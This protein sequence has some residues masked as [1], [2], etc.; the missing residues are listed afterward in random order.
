MTDREEQGFPYFFG[1]F[2]RLF[3]LEILHLD[4][5]CRCGVIRSALQ[6]EQEE[7][8]RGSVEGSRTEDP[9]VNRRWVLDSICPPGRSSLPSLSEAKDLLP[10][11]RGRRALLSA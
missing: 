4:I 2:F 5:V 3:V 9:P 6:E 10:V 1:L 7:I 8:E 11:L